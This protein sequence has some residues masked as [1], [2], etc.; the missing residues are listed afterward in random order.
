MA[1]ASGARAMAEMKKPA[2]PGAAH[3]GGESSNPL[4]GVAYS[5]PHRLRKPPRG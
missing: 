2:R 4:A 3:A 1:V 5:V